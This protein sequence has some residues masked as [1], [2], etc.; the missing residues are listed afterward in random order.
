MID[1]TIRA[2][3]PDTA[4]Q[5]SQFIDPTVRRPKKRFRRVLP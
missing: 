1:S 4:L 2:D 3:L 5:V